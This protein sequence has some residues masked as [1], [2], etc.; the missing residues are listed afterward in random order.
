MID[1][2]LQNEVPFGRVAGPFAAPLFPSL[3]MSHFGVI[4]KN[5]QP[6]NWCLIL[7]L[8]SPE[9]QSIN[10]GIPKPPFTAQYV[11]VDAFIDGIMS[12]GQGTLMANFNV[13]SAYR[14]VAIH[15]DDCPLLGMQWRGQYFVDL[16]LLF[17]LR[18]APFI[19]TAIVDLVEWILVHNYD[20]TFLCHYLD[21]FLTFLY[22][23]TAFKPVFICVD[24][25]ASP[26]I[27]M[28]WRIL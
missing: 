10:D 5:N 12:L 6:G 16:A 13:A 8:S 3:H 22:A 14:D 19:V 28:S 7:D 11:S 21:D 17:G 20:V 26:F 25:L 4:S 24:N 27:Q 2:Y 23:T 9:R 15:P 1:S 18:S